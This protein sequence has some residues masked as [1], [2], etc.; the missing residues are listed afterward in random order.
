MAEIQVAKH[1]LEKSRTFQASD[2]P[3][4]PPDCLS[5]LLVCTS[6]CLGAPPPQTT[7]LPVFWYYLTVHA[8]NDVYCPSTYSS[9]SIWDEAL[10]STPLAAS[11]TS[12]SSTLI[13]TAA[14]ELVPALA[15][16]LNPEV[17][18]V[19][20]GSPLL[21]KSHRSEEPDLSGPCPNIVPLCQ[22]RIP[23]ELLR[24]SDSS[25]LPLRA[26]EGIAMLFMPASKMSSE[27]SL[28]AERR[29]IISQASKTS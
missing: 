7:L 13:S 21:A 6:Y 27:S 5:Q 19:S 23:A 26:G 17:M 18:S 29:A 9:S 12:P 11:A 28:S 24:P 16:N 22:L 4:G 8:R 2:R 3:N 14:G 15:G 10:I 25:S 20:S 1:R